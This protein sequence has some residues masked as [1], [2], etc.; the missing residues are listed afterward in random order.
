MTDEH[1]MTDEMK[2]MHAAAMQ[3]ADERDQARTE[4]GLWRAAFVKVAPRC[5]VR[6][7]VRIAAVE[8]ARGRHCDEH[9]AFYSVVPQPLPWA[10]AA[11]RVNAEGGA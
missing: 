7:C 6:D 9:G 1:E 5:E 2:D 8:A 11:R 4:A 10:D 3:F